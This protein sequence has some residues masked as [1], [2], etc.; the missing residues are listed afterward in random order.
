MRTRP[1]YRRGSISSLA[2][3]RR[4]QP[5]AAA[6]KCDS[7]EAPQPSLDLGVCLGEVLDGC[8]SLLNL[9]LTDNAAHLSLIA[10]RLASTDH[11]QAVQ[12]IPQ[13]IAE[14]RTSA[15]VVLPPQAVGTQPMPN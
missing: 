7:P 11:Q 15:Q 2:Q 9:E 14:L 13:L 6:F 1:Q 3:S 5:A 10:T 8:N 12:C 4:R